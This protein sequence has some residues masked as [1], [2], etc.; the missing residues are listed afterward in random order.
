[1]YNR[2]NISLSIFL[3]LFATVFVVMPFISSCNK[4]GTVAPSSLN[5]QYQVINLSP[6][7]GP[8]DLYIN[9]LKVNTSSFYY[10]TPSGYFFL[11][12]IV[13]PFQIRPATGTTINGVPVSTVPVFSIDSI[14]KPNLKYTLFITGLSSVDSVR[15]IFVPDTAPLPTVGRGKLRFINASPRS[16]DLDLTANGI[17]PSTG[18]FT[19]LSYLKVSPYVELPAGNYNFQIY[20]TGNRT[21]VLLKMLNFTIEDGR[22]YT[23]YC[24]GLEGHT[25]DTV[26]F[27]SNIV[28]NK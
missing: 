27:G 20:P 4:S 8:L 2:N 22:L 11:T 16:Q 13:T 6:D 24:Y 17:S 28:T 14:L 7:Q 12:S 5:I 9:F 26:A 23:M 15:P 18:E 1:M 25:T 3:F 19:K 10:P 21:N